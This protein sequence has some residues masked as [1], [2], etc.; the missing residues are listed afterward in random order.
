MSAA[1]VLVENL[2]K[3]YSG[4]TVVDSLS[5]QARSGELTALLGP[6]GAGKTTTIECCEGL[7]QP[8]AGAVRIL[9][10]DPAT[11]TPDQRARVGVMLQDGGLPTG[12]RAAEL[13]H[14]VAKLYRNPLD[15]AELIERLGIS[16]FARTSV[17]RLSGGQRQR[18]SLG[19]AI[20]G[21]PQVVF[22]DEPSAGLD[23]Q[24]RLAV[25]ELVRE[26]KADGVAIVLTT[27]LMDEAE[28]LAD[29][30]IIMDHGA[31]LAA[32]SP[33]ELLAHDQ[34]T[35]TVNFPTE[36][37]AELALAGLSNVESL[38]TGFSITLQGQA[39]TLTGPTSPQA[40]AAVASAL[41]RQ[42]LL[43][44]AIHTGPQTLENLFL[45]LTGRQLR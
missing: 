2:T 3:V 35:I 32:G 15:P 23:P 1:A 14:H 27:H 40:L 44:T 7:R 6:N 4:R 24:A 37:E 8:D 20:I 30:V 10:H 45:D 34:S 22:L 28:Q 43:A 42:D 25:W 33:S 9:G 13:L 29:E 36:P 17:R 26:L 31:I 41:A 21:R 11:A 38:A 5:F 16:S 19:A 18:V 12:V 39:L